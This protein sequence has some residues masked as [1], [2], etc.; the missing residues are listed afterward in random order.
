MCSLVSL[1]ESYWMNGPE[2]RFDH[3]FLTRKDVLSVYEAAGLTVLQTALFNI[4]PRGQ[5]L[6]NDCK[7]L[8]FVGAQK[9]KAK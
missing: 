1:E 7:A 4:P 9:P 6:F 5:G 2:Q 8:L 3:L